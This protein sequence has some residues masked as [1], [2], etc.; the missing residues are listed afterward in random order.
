MLLAIL[1][2]RFASTFPARYQEQHPLFPTM[3]VTLVA[4][5]S[6]R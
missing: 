1:Y 2:E 3:M 4:I 5:D 6:L